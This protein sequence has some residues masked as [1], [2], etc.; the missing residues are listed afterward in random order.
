MTQPEHTP[1]DDDVRRIV[2]H[3]M[4]VLFKQMRE[5]EELWSTVPRSVAP[6]VKSIFASI[7]RTFAIQA[8]RNR[9]Q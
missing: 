6:V 8:I 5:S 4:A 2:R 3:E 9:R 1:D 7:E